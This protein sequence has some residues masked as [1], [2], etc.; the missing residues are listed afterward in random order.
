LVVVIKGPVAIAG[1]IFNLFSK[2]GTK[3]PKSE[4]KIITVI[5]A[6]ETVNA[7]SVELLNTKL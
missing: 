5:R 4:A 3:V 1:S 7:K 6:T 2:S